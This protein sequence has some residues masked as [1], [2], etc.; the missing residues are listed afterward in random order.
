MS[1]KIALGGVLLAINIIILMLINII[2]INTLFLMGI[3]SLL[4]SIIIMEFGP[5]MGVA[6]YLGV[7]ILSFFVMANKFQWIL[8]IF[9]FG[10]YGLFKYIIEQDRSVY[11]E[12][13]LKLIFA[14][15]AIGIVFFMIKEF[16]YIPINI[17]TIIFFE[18]AFLVY[19]HVYS[20]FIEYYNN[21]LKKILKKI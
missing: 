14:N 1:K 20:L 6:F 19:D 16:I 9:T 7:F 4:I 10:V 2:P 3:A 5:K 13:I 15:I 18:V 17:F 8:Y 11:I 21:K 12:Y